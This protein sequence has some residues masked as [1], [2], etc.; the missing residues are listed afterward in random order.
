MLVTLLTV[1]AVV[2]WLASRS[3]HP[4][5]ILPDSATE[6]ASVFLGSPGH[7]LPNQNKQWLFLAERVDPVGAKLC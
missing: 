3:P 5:T 4:P 7:D 2:S 6:A 1:V